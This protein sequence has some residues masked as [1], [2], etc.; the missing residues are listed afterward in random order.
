MTSNGFLKNSD[1]WDF[2]GGPMV[3][4][5]GREEGRVRC[6]ERATWKLTLPHEK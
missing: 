4:D 5:M 2:P 6:M 1:Y 3:T